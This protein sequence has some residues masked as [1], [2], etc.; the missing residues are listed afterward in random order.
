MHIH[1]SNLFIKYKTHTHTQNKVI[2]IH[3]ENWDN[4]QECQK[5]FKTLD[6]KLVGT[7]SGDVLWYKGVTG[8]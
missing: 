2:S 7:E 4:E 5:K 8:I 1:E 3:E 6:K